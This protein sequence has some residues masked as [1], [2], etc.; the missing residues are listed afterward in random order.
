[1]GAATLPQL[2]QTS[3][4][5]FFEMMPSSF[6][7]NHAKQKGY[8]DLING[9]R[10]LFRPLDQE[11]KARSLNLSCFHI[12]ECSEVAY[13][14]FVQLTTRLRNHAT[15]N[16]IGILSTNPDMGW[17]KTD[18]LLKSAKIHNATEKYFIPEEDKNPNFSTHIAPTHLNV[19][20]PKNFYDDTAKGRPAWW[21]ARYLDG[22]FS[23]SEGQVFPMFQQHIVD[24]FPIPKNWERVGG[25]D[26]GI[27][28]PTVM[29]LGAINP[30]DG[31]MYI[32]DEY[33]QNHH[34]VPHHAK[35]MNLKLE[36]IPHG[37][38]RFLVAD[39][40]GKRRNMTDHS[41]LYDHYAEYGIYF[42]DGNNRIESGI[43]KVYTW[44]MLGKLKVFSTCRNTVRE[45]LNYK[46]KPIELDAKK[47]PDEKP[48]D[49]DNHTCDALRYIIS[50]LPD[51]PK[52]LIQK[53]WNPRDFKNEQK[54]EYLPH[55][56][57]EEEEVFSSDWMNY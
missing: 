34:A 9:H 7:S 14:F 42:K 21:V 52:A 19:H 12:E 30:D 8:V 39:P 15:K 40:S 57:Q 51:D 18:F 32:Y 35:E 50:E 36:D 11:G 4:K 5:T 53:S 1:M 54:Q 3:M 31:V 23:H 56:L 27:V 24:P 28:D 17:V 48:I 55:A 41:S 38:L 47:N 2:E 22:S 45:H 43:S 26:F 49:K 33:Y 16:H 44:L 25:A 37:A 29:L 6:I 10:V 20:L 46:Y 13:D